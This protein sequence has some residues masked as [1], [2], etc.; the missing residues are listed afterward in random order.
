MFFPAGAY[1]LTITP[2]RFKFFL[3]ILGVFARC[4]GTC[5]NVGLSLVSRKRGAFL[6]SR[7]C[8]APPLWVKSAGGI[9]F[10]VLAKCPTYFL[11]KFLKKRLGRLPWSCAYGT[12]QGSASLKMLP[13]PE[14][15]SRSANTRTARPTTRNPQQGAS[16]ATLKGL[17]ATT[18]GNS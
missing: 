6:F 10:S 13:T 5:G 9:F 3:S 17:L 2:G 18:R 4:C 14:N 1:G 16:G 12:D 7:L 11:R 15:L 8:I